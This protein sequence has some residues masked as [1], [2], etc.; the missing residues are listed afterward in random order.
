MPPDERV[1]RQT[2]MAAPAMGSASETPAPLRTVRRE[3]ARREHSFEPPQHWEQ[4]LRHLDTLC[5][6]TEGSQKAV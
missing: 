2:T 4:E 5:E 1:R 6:T 3:S